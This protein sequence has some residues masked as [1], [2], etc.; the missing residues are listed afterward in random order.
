MSNISKSKKTRNYEYLQFSSSYKKLELFIEVFK[1]FSLTLIL[2]LMAFSQVLHKQ[3][4]F[5]I[6][7]HRFG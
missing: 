2:P 5:P 3:N 4:L 6:R 1:K 7:Q